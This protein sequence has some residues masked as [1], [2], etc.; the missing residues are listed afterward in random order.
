MDTQQYYAILREQRETLAKQHPSGFC[1]VVSLDD[2]QRNVKAGAVC[3]VSVADCARLL[4]D[5]THRVATPAEVEAYRD[6]QSVARARIVRDDV[7]RVKQMFDGVMR[8]K[9]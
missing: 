4:L 6:R 8:G 5:R 9:I 1:L 2:P 3:E 7:D